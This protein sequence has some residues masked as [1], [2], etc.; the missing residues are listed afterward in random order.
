M[1]T[2]NSPADR[3]PS[4]NLTPGEFADDQEAITADGILLVLDVL[5]ET[6]AEHVIYHEPDGTAHT[7][8]THESNKEYDPTAPVVIS[9]YTSSLNYHLGEQDS[10]TG[11]RVS[12]I[13]EAYS[14]GQ[15]EIDRVRSYPFPAD[16]L[17]PHS[18]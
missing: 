3:S 5:E 15:L 14:D 6:A 10:R 7:V 4:T 13:L 12:E 16:R 9:C 2:P 18:P 8:A 11:W 17:T 1:S